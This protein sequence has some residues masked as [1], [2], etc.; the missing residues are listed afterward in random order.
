MATPTL[1]YGRKYQKGTNWIT[2]IAMGAFHVGAAEIDGDRNGNCDAN[3]TC[4]LLQNHGAWQGQGP[5]VDVG[6]TAD[7]QKIVRFQDAQ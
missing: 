7:S 2:V 6:T 1:M 4:L 3:E 5:L